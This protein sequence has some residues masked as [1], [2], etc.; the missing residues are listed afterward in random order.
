MRDVLNLD[1]ALHDESVADKESFDR[2]AE[3]L[4][5]LM[6]GEA[7]DLELQALLNEMGTDDKMRATWERYQKVSTLLKREDVAPRAS[8][9]F[10][11]RVRAAIA[12]EPVPAPMDVRTTR[13]VE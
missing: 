9:G 1:A 13:S 3:S 2:R 4:S 12:N 5:A 6:D 8:L 10:A 11:D 7:T